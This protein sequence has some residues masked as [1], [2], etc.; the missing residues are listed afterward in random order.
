MVHIHS[1]SYPNLYHKTAV[2]EDVDPYPV[3][4]APPR[5]SFLFLD[6]PLSSSLAFFFPFPFAIES[7]TGGIF[8]PLR[9]V[10]NISELTRIPAAITKIAFGNAATVSL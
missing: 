6:R 4:A 10:T 5:K 7:P 3:A 9:T 8:G 1:I 2:L